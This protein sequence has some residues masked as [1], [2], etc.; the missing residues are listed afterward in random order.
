MKAGCEVATLGA[1][2]AVVGLLL[3]VTRWPDMVCAE[4]FPQLACQLVHNLRFSALLGASSQGNVV[5][6]GLVCVFC[7][8]VEDTESAV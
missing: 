8:A 3:A 2:G 6:M 1:F 5:F 7:R 4:P